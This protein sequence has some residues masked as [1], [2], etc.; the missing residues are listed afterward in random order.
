MEIFA[1]VKQVPDSVSEIRISSDPRR[2]EEAGIKFVMNPFDE[3]AVEEAIRIKERFVDAR[4]T[5]LCCGPERAVES[6]RMA[7]AMGADRGL[8]AWDPAFQDQDGIAT[9]RVLAAALKGR[10][11][12]LILA[13]KHA[14]DDVNHTVP[15]ALA[16]FLGLP[17]V[18]G[19]T[20]L[21]LAADGKSA[22]ARRRIE[23]GEEIVDV[24]LPA[25]I[26][27][28][29]GIN[30]PRYPSLPGLMKAKK[31]ELERLTLAQLGLATS[32]VGLEGSPTR[33]TRLSPPP[34]RSQ[35]KIIARPTLEES[36]AELVR[37]LQEEA[38]VL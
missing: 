15:S 23:G 9:A 31:K 33:V 16:E 28:E 20:R 12:D 32:D 35:A 27:C 2:T 13:G 38:K 7:L 4:V 19:V 10:A 5:A 1:L 22:T 21:E 29:K 34:P 17:Q 25:V 8:H 30:D 26:T 18:N 37:L 36:V 14:I 24:L 6:I 11:V 3:F